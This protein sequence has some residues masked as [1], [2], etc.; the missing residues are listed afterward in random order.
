QACG[1]APDG[2]GGTLQCGGCSDQGASTCGTTGQCAGGTCALYDSGT[3]CQAATCPSSTSSQP[4]CNC[5]GQGHC[6][7]PGTVNCAPYLCRNGAC[8]TSC[9]TDLDCAAGF[10]C[11]GGVCLAQETIGLACTAPDQCASGH[12]VDG[13]CCN[14]AC[15]G[16]CQA[17]SAAK[18]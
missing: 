10:Y 12:C 16:T 13:V 8:A 6:L 1:T 14:T 2:C 11:A 9:S 18:K 7:C 17:C 5:D 15:T 3:V 4:A